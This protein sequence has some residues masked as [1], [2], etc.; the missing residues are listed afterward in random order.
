[1]AFSVPFIIRYISLSMTLMPGDLIASGT[2][3]GVSK[4]AEND[5]VEVEVEGIGV[6]RNRVMNS[7]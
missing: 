5:E 1:M 3:A 4:L 6:L 2:P 7:G